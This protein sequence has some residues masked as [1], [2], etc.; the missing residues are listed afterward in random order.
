MLYEVITHKIIDD[1]NDRI[2]VTRITLDLDRGIYHENFN[3][4]NLAR[5]L[6]VHG[7]EIEKETTLSGVLSNLI[8]KPYVN[9]T[10]ARNVI[11]V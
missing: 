9:L 6:K 8:V 10:T 2:T 5:L 11:V 3:M 7:D 1:K 4:D